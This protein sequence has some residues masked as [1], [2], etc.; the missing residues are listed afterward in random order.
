MRLRSLTI[1][2]N[3]T[4]SSRVARR[5]TVGEVVTVW[6]VSFRLFAWEPRIIA[7]NPCITE[8][9]QSVVVTNQLCVISASS[10][11]LRFTCLS[12][13]FTA[14]AQRTQRLR[15]ENSHQG[16]YP[17]PWLNLQPILLRKSFKSGVLSVSIDTQNSTRVTWSPSHER[18]RTCQNTS[19]TSNPA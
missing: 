16:Y 8:L 3:P 5:R 18:W 17:I 11:P 6:L 4:R 14:E 13:S 9:V 7:V 19:S 10:A 1:S 15:R 12:F 2:E